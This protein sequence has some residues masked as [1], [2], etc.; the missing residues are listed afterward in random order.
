MQAEECA[1]DGAPAAGDESRRAGLR[2]EERAEGPKGERKGRNEFRHDLD[3]VRDLRPLPT[4]G[5]NL[6]RICAVCWPR[7]TGKDRQHVIR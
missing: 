1:L 6:T 3:D 5:R 7:R 2:A 4:E